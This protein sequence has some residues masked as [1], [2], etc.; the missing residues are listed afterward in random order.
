[1]DRSPA[2]DGFNREEVLEQKGE[3]SQWQLVRYR[4]RYFSDGVILDEI[5]RQI[6]SVVLYQ[7]RVA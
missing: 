1:M 3:L 7:K 2:G 5:K 4:V 6:V